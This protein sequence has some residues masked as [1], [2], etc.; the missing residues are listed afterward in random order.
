MTL[1]K[2]PRPSALLNDEQDQSNAALTM[3]KRK[4]S[5]LH[6]HPVE[7]Q[8]Y[9][10]KEGKTFKMKKKVLCRLH[11]AALMVSQKDDGL[12]S[13]IITVTKC[14]PGT[15][16]LEICVMDQNQHTTSFFADT[17]EECLQWQA[18]LKLAAD[19]DIAKVYSFGPILGKG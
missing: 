5:F 16:K 1:P 7:M 13:K 12:P 19:R 4:A 18:A 2:S 11:D 15:R 10:H 9:L 3:F 17:D 14:I 8:G 6:G